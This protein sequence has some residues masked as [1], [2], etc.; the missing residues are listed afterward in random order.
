MIE[1]FLAPA[2]PCLCEYACVWCECGGRGESSEPPEIC[3]NY[4]H[5]P[6]IHPSVRPSKHLEPS[7][8]AFDQQF[9]AA[10]PEQMPKPLNKYRAAAASLLLRTQPQFSDDGGHVL[11]GGV[12][13]RC[14]NVTVLVVRRSLNLSERASFSLHSK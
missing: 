4:E 11:G 1:G 6:R 7:I 2:F 3:T 5:G 10:N 13:D 8:L 14:A 9:V 12:F